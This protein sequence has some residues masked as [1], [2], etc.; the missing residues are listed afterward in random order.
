M[1]RRARWRV[2]KEKCFHALPADGAPQLAAA[3]LF[4][5]H[6]GMP[7]RAPVDAVQVYGAAAVRF[8]Q[9]KRCDVRMRVGVNA[10]S[11]R[12]TYIATYRWRGI[13][14]PRWSEDGDVFNFHD[15]GLRKIRKFGA[16]FVCI[17]T[18]S[19][20]WVYPG[21]KRVT[22]VDRRRCPCSVCTWWQSWW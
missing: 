4:E 22:V 9:Y 2:V 8:M 11:I 14:N 13:I 16:R 15:Y 21:F 18:E 1:L 17:K 7:E 10:A 6:K 5:P 3:R 19:W 12:Y 20:W